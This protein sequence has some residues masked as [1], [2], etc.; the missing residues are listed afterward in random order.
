MISSNKNYCA[1]EVYG[2]VLFKLAVERQDVDNIKS[3][4]EEVEKFMLAEGAFMQVMTSPYFSKEQKGTVIEKLFGEKFSELTLNFLLTAVEHNR[5]GSLYYVIKKFTRLYRRM[6]GHREVW[7]TVSQALSPI[8][9]E[10]IKANLAAALKTDKITLEFNVEQE[11]LGGAIIRYG[12]KMIDNSVRT[13]L[14]R[15][16][17]S[18]ITQGRNSRKEL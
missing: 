4:L 14:N 17:D 10:S 1:G 7:M 5:M 13:R 6:T 16:V 18:I 3:D 11:I 2:D 12:G 15:A 9:I 8:E